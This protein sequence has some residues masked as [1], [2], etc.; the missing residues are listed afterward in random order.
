ML[1]TPSETSEPDASPAEGKGGSFPG[2]VPQPQVIR[3]H[4]HFIQPN[5]SLETLFGKDWV[6]VARFNRIDRRHVYPGMTIKVPDIMDGIRGYTPLPSLYEPARHQ[7][8][9]ILVDITEQWLGAYEHGRLVFSVPAATGRAEAATPTGMFRSVRG[10][11]TIRRRS[12]R[13]RMMRS[14]IPWTTP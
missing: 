14:S 13:H 3:W 10:T 9:Y 1:R 7:E 4:P 2:G 5:E 6:W 11:G 12:T 8:K